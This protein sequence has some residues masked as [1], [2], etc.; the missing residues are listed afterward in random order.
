MVFG[1]FPT[2]VEKATHHPPFVT[3]TIGDQKAF[4]KINMPG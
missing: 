1:D 3:V 2:T 4:F